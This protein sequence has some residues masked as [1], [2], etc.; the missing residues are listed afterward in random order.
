MTIFSFHP[1]KA[2]TAGEGGAVN[3]NNESFYKR[4]KKLRNHGITKNEEEFQDKE[5]AYSNSGI[6]N[7]WYYEQTELGFNYRLSDI[8]SALATS[9]L[10]KLSMFYKLRKEL[11]E[12]YDI[13]LK[14]LFPN[15]RPTRKNSHTDPCLHIYS[16]LIDFKAINIERCELIKK[17]L[18]KGIM[19][20]VHYI[21]VYKHPYYKKMVGSIEL[22]NSEYYYDHTLTLPLYP[23][24]SKADVRRVV[25]E[26][27]AVIS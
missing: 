13:L 22:P 24:M 16:I 26:L 12:L 8:N 14:P 23:S 7:P 9:Q 18:E 15:V 19:T 2:I 10:N 6:L 3:C 27:V 17:L 20:Q 25:E 1:V 5:N 11:S 21:P 4:L